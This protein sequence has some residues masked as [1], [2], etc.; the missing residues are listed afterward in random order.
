MDNITEYI[1]TL[2]NQT[3]RERFQE[4][5][6]WINSTYP[7]LESRVAWNQPMFT[8]HGTFI[9][10]FSS[11]KKHIAV[12]PEIAGIQKFSEAINKSG[13]NHSK[14]IFQIPWDMHVDYGL[15]KQMIDFNI[16]DKADCKTF[17]RKG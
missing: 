4:I 8:D 12:T 11:A 14:M 9:I 2:E 17:W 6:S 5:F 1:D 13:Y 15:L 16:R 3:H 10:A 7:Q